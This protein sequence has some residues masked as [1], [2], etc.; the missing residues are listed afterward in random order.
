[1]LSSRALTRFSGPNAAFVP[2]LVGGAP[3]AVV[4]DL[5]RHFIS[6]IWINRSLLSYFLR[7][8]SMYTSAR[9]YWEGIIRFGSMCLNP[10]DS[11]SRIAGVST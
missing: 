6:P 3:A 11:Y 1:M 9:A 4:V 5:V 10:T 2:G 7:N 8:N